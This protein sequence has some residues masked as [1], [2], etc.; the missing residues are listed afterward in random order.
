MAGMTIHFSGRARAATVSMR[1]SSALTA[2]LAIGALQ[3][4]K[5]FVELLELLCLERLPQDPERV[6]NAAAVL[7]GKCDR[8][9]LP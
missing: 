6:T 8:P 1:L 9:T 7:A 4:R 3:L 5:P 2:R